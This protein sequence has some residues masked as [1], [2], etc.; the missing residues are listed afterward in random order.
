MEEELGTYTFLPW[1]K[2]GLGA[3]ILQNGPPLIGPRASLDVQVKIRKYPLVGHM[4]EI[5]APKKT[6]ELMGPGDVVGVQKKFIIRRDPEPNSNSVER[7]YFPLI[8]FSQ[9]DFP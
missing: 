5:D 2:S 4:E 8:E 3:H 7:N 1:V 6:V 9:A